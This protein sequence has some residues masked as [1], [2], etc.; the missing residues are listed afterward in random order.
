MSITNDVN[1][2]LLSVMQSLSESSK[3][4]NVRQHG[5]RGCWRRYSSY[6]VDGFHFPAVYAFYD[7]Y[8]NIMYIFSV[9]IRKM[10]ELTKKPCLSI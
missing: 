2:D 5:N 8:D 6:C 10:C 1:H 7:E 9:M 4:N 3:S